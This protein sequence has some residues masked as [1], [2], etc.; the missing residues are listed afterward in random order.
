MSALVAIG[1]FLI[2]WAMVVVLVRYTTGEWPW[3]RWR[4]PR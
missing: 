2:I 3:Q 1:G 4:R